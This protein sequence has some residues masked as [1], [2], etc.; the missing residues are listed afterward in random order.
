MRA[1]QFVAT[2]DQRGKSK[3][4]WGKQKKVFAVGT[5]DSKKEEGRA[6]DGSFLSPIG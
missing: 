1:E 5:C 6:W 2:G 3:R 4:E